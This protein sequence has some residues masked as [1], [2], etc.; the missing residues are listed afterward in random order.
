MKSDRV[1]PAIVWDVPSACGRSGRVGAL[2]SIDRAGRAAKKP[3]RTVKAKDSGCILKISG[4]REK[5]RSGMVYI[6]PM[7]MTRH[8]RTV[9]VKTVPRRHGGTG[10]PSANK[11]RPGTGRSMVML[12]DCRHPR[13][14]SGGSRCH[15]VDPSS[16]GSGHRPPC[17]RTARKNAPKDR[18]APLTG[19][20]R[21]VVTSPFGFRHSVPVAENPP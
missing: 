18:R 12:Y 1:R 11:P 8:G 19:V 20:T 10:N 6:L 14:A 16:R 17:G 9:P 7:V 3:R 2:M 4:P 15:S 21:A 5:G 13:P